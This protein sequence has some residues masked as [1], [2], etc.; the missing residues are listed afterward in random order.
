MN[1]P[2]HDPLPKEVSKREAFRF[3]LRL[4]FISFGGP[5]GQISVMHRELVEEKRWISEGRFLHAL[6]YCMVLPGPEA[7]QLA[8]Y[9]GWLMH[10]SWGG[11]VAG[12]LFILPSLFILIALS[13]IYMAFG[14]LPIV[15]GI[16]AAVKPTVV[17]IILHAMVRIGK[18]TLITPA[19]KIISCVAF[20]AFFT[21][22][23]PFPLII[24]FA[25]F[26]GFIFPKWFTATAA[27]KGVHVGN[28]VH[29]LAIF[30]DDSPI[31]SHAHWTLRRSVK[32]AL[33]FLCLGGMPLL[34]LRWQDHGLTFLFQLAWFFTKAAFVSFGGAYA[35]LPYVQ[36]GVV[37]HFH[38]LSTAQMM[39]GLALGESTPGPLIMVVTFVGF[40]SGWLQGGWGPDSVALAGVVAALLVTWFTFLP[41]FFFILVG[42]PF[43]ESTRKNIKFSGPLNGIMA[44]VVGA[45][46][47][48]GVSFGHQTFWPETKGQFSPMLLAGIFG[49]AL[50]ALFWKKRSI[51]EVVIASAAIGGMINLAG[52]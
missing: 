13:W 51:L 41:S 23:I 26:C 29:T 36:Q 33:V 37:D 19:Q 32:V 28:Q 24:C 34:V 15:M 10:R 35:V 6:N 5:A 25:G 42:A 17:A 39:D 18:K 50:V 22:S 38:W 47:Q 21:R 27:V 3:W 49:L 30:D 40:L 14:Q 45:I 12:G 46:A 4:G 43:I 7:Q 48:L 16:F 2:T 20:L 44:A 1:E 31:P 8:T 9:L 52:L 11:I